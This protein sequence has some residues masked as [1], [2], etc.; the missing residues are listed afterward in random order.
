MSGAVVVAHP[1]TGE[2]VELHTASDE[3]L[4]AL[5]VGAEEVAMQLKAADT[6]IQTEVRSRMDRSGE[7][8]RRVVID[9]QAW[10]FTAP[11]P[12]AGATEY[13]PDALEIVLDDLVQSGTID[14]SL[15]E[16]ALQR[17]VTVVLSVPWGT[18]ITAAVER[19]Q[20]LDDAT[21]V[22]HST[23]VGLAAIAKLLKLPGAAPAIKTVGKSIVVP[24]DQRRVKF[25]AA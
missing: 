10:K 22:K 3:Q 18:E 23:K 13:D 25:E 14:S 24:D 2:V 8:T 19:A 1:R 16:S 11:S 17:T 6:A 12:N 7:W 15:A 21:T 4:A 5:R 9:G 20:G